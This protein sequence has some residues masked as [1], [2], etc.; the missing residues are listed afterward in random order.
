MSVDVFDW[1]AGVSALSCAKALALLGNKG[2]SSRAS[3]TKVAWVVKYIDAF[4]LIED[5][6]LDNFVGVA[7]ALVSATT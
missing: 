4:Y 6:S 3:G 1:G 2:R 7:D 5:T